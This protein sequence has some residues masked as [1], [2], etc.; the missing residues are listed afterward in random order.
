MRGFHT[1]YCHHD[2][3]GSFVSSVCPQEGVSVFVN[4]PGSPALNDECSISLIPKIT[5]LFVQEKA[6]SQLIHLVH[7]TLSVKSKFVSSNLRTYML[8]VN[9]WDANQEN[10]FMPKA[11]VAEPIPYICL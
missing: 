3:I 10:T 7:Q 2:V 6:E 9:S 11:V 4:V 5:G 1:L 8:S